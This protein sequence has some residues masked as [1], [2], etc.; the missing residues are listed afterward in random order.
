M[1]AMREDEGLKLY[2]D[3]YTKLYDSYY[4]MKEENMGHMDEIHSLKVDVDYINIVLDL[5]S[6]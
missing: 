4:K 3:V 6:I 2:A 1:E 5:Y